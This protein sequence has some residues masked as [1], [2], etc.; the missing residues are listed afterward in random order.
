[1][2]GQEFNTVYPIFGHDDCGCGCNGGKCKPQFNLFHYLPILFL[3]W[4]LS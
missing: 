2:T 3:C 1:M 4:Y